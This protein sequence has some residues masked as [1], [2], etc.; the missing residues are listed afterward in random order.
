MFTNHSKKK[1]HIFHHKNGNFLTANNW[2][3]STPFEVDF[4]VESES[5]RQWDEVTEQ[6][7]ALEV[8]GTTN[9]EWGLSQL[10]QGIMLG[11]L[12]WNCLE[13]R[14]NKDWAG[15]GVQFWLRQQCQG[16]DTA[17]CLGQDAAGQVILKGRRATVTCRVLNHIPPLKSL[18]CFISLC[19]H[20]GLLALFFFWFFF[21]LKRPVFWQS[22]FTWRLG[23][24]NPP[25]FRR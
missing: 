2:I 7:C 1:G 5:P 13:K 8:L 4:S 17:A 19:L 18:L 21:F 24:K 23:K 25:F 11:Y 12:S 6:S 10:Y 14:I 16:W 9:A 3:F 22:E 20:H 15:V